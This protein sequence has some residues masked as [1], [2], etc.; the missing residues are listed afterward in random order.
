MNSIYL[1][2]SFEEKAHSWGYCNE[3]LIALAADFLQGVSFVA[4]KIG[5][6]LPCLYGGIHIERSLRENFFE[7]GAEISKAKELL[8]DDDLKQFLAKTIEKFVTS[9]KDAVENNGVLSSTGDCRGA[10]KYNT[11]DR[12]EYRNYGW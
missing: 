7:A 11:G 3:V 12:S 5:C 6:R 2:L 8:T 1:R 10:C 4:K 9:V